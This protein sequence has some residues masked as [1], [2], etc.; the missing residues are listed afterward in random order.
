MII[1]TDI[2]VTFYA[3]GKRHKISDH[4]IMSYIALEI[5]LESEH[6]SE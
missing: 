6:L 3:W 5:T 2:A 1:N 4:K